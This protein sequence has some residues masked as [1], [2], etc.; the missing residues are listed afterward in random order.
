MQDRNDQER[1]R[2]ALNWRMLAGLAAIGLLMP[3][4]ATIISQSMRANNLRELAR[5]I[6]IGDRIDDMDILLGGSTYGYEW[7][8]SNGASV[9][10]TGAMYG[11]SLNTVH[12]KLDGLVSRT[13]FGTQWYNTALSQHPKDWPVLIKYNTDRLVTAVFIDGQRTGPQTAAD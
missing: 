5:S 12:E 1:V 8:A 3:I 11:G 13:S 6:R 4:A 9:K 2:H 10:E 7:W